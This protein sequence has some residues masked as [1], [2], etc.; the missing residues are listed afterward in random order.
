MVRDRVSFPMGSGQVPLR[1]AAWGSRWLLRSV[2]WW[3]I[4][5]DAGLCLG[6]SLGPCGASALHV[7]LWVLQGARGARPT[8]P[9][10]ALE[11]TIP[12]GLAWPCREGGRT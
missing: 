4:G 11:Q 1:T 10:V 9:S 7:E 8:E 5:W 3:G 6:L 12:W 2:G